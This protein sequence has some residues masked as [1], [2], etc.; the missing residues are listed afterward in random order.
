MG[1]LESEVKDD[2]SGVAAMASGFVFGYIG[3][4]GQTYDNDYVKWAG[5][6]LAGVC[7]L[8]LGYKFLGFCDRMSRETGR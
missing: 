5:Y 1:D 4:I 2:Y 6:G 3:W 7:A 8:Y